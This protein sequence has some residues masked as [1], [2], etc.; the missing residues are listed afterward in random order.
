MMDPAMETIRIL[1]D[2]LDD[3]TRELV[4]KERKIDDLYD[5]NDKLVDELHAAQCKQAAP[6]PYTDHDVIRAQ[7]QALI[8]ALAHKRKID[9]I[10]AY[11]ALTGEG[12]KESKDQVERIA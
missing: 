4:G 3:K 12:L 7:M 11:R 1:L 5:R 2:R 8:D 9:A 10:K 6:Q